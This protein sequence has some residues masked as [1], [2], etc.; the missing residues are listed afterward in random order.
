VHWVASLTTLHLPAHGLLRLASAEQQLLV[1][2]FAASFASAG[3]RLRALPSG[4]FLA[5]GTALPEGVETLDPAQCLGANLA[6]ALPQGPGA[7]ALRRLGAEIEMWLHEH[8][9][10]ITRMRAGQPPISTL[11]LW[12]GGAR[13]AT[14][15]RAGAGTSQ[16]TAER[17][18]QGSG[19]RTSPDS[20]AAGAMRRASRA[21][22]ER[23]VLSEDPYM[24]GLALLSGRQARAPVPSFAE[25]APDESR[26]LVPIDLTQGAAHPARTLERLDEAWIVPALRALDQ[27]AL[28][29]LLL[30]TGRQQL[31]LGAHSRLKIWRRPRAP[32]AVLA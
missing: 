31:T 12:G 10:N 30:V 29:R 15:A 28:A 14:R 24:R 9:V 19:V 4:G 27:G 20:A 25:L 2:S 16:G 3:F 17:F 13:L 7:A 18:G 23:T 11:W 1:E 5:L 22:D 21:A 6:E 32:L 8:P 26:V